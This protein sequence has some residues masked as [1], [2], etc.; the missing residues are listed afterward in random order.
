MTQFLDCSSTK[1]YQNLIKTYD[2]SKLLE[3]PCIKKYQKWKDN[4]VYL[5]DDKYYKD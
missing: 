4:E 3:D 1:S 2:R 5:K